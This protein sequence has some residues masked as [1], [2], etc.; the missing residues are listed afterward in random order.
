MTKVESWRDLGADWVEFTIKRPP[1][2]D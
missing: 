2:A 1:S